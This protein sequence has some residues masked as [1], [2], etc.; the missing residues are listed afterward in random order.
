MAPKL[1]GT[2]ILGTVFHRDDLMTDDIPPLWIGVSE[3]RGV[4]KHL[5][6]GRDCSLNYV[7]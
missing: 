3:E 6:R 1:P 5:Q 4:Y 7:H 2:F